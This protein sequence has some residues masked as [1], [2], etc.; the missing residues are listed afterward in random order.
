VRDKSALSLPSAMR[1]AR[2]ALVAGADRGFALAGR[3]AL[4]THVA[5]IGAAT[6]RGRRPVQP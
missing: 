1:A 2:I 5:W 4:A 6:D 3:T